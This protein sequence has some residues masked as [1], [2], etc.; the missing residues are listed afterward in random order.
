LGFFPLLISRTCV[1]FSLQQNGR[2]L[3]LRVPTAT[4]STQHTRPTTTAESWD[5]SCASPWC[6]AAVDLLIWII[7][8]LVEANKG[9]MQ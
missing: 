7:S 5:D 1:A 3:A 4:W 2:F 6:S 9:K 8:D